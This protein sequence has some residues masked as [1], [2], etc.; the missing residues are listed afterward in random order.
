MKLIRFDGPANGVEYSWMGRPKVG[1]VFYVTD[2]DWQEL[3]V[4]AGVRFAL[5]EK[6]KKLRVVNEADV[7]R[8]MERDLCERS[9]LELIEM[10]RKAVTVPIPSAR[11]R[12]YSRRQLARIIM[13]K[14]I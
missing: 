13:T 11:I 6:T 14:T 3:Q 2:R 8:V 9:R 5:C 12:I 7:N 4:N 1:D 10:A